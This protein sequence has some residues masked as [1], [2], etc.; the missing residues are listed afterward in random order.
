MGGKEGGVE[1]ISGEKRHR[2]QHCTSQD[3]CHLDH[4]VIFIT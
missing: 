1:E 4:L 2:D 3:N